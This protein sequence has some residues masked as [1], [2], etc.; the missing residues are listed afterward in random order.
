MLAPVRTATRPAGRQR[1][2]PDAEIDGGEVSRRPPDS[3]APAVEDSISKF[4]A[5][6]A[7]SLTTGKVAG[8][9]AS[10][11]PIRVLPLTAVTAGAG[12]VI[13]AAP[14]PLLSGW[15]VELPA[16]FERLLPPAG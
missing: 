5:S 3:A 7:N 11:G 8:S 9:F 2:R 1:P 12:D 13:F 14:Q 15:G 4:G 10:Q 16:L 6:L